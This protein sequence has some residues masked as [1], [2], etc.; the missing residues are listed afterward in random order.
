[1]KYQVGNRVNGVI[2]NITDLGVFLTLPG[3]KSGLIHFS[4]FGDNWQRERNRLKVGDELRVVV[5]HNHKG[6]LALSL[7]RVNDPKLRDL[8]NRFLDV[9]ANDFEKTLNKTSEEAKDEIKK[10]KKVLAEN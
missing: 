6:K 7:S 5:V 4:D 10:L 3:R 1:M 2:N 8:H 9:S